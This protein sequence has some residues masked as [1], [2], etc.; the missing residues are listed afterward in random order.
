MSKS[1]A[2]STTFYGL[3]RVNRAK[4]LFMKLTWALIT[5]GSVSF[6]VYIIT[7]TVLNYLKRGV[8][9]STHRINP[10]SN[11]LPSVTFCTVEAI[12]FRTNLFRQAVFVSKAGRTN[13]TGQDFH[14]V[15]LAFGDIPFYHCIK[16]NNYRAEQ[17]LYSVKNTNYDFFLFEV[18]EK[19][20]FTRLE[21]FFSDNYLNTVD[22]S[23]YVAAFGYSKTKYYFEV[24]KSVEKIREEP[25]NDCQLI[26]DLNYRRSNCLLQCQSNKFEANYNCT[27]RN[28][29]AKSSA[30]EY[31]DQIKNSTLFEFSAVCESRCLKECISIKFEAQLEAEA[32][33]A[34]MFLDIFYTDLSY[35]EISQTPIMNGYS[36]INE[37]GGALGLFVGISFLSI[38]EL[39]EYSSEILLILFK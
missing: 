13:L 7:N 35:I 12:E 25:Y 30:L 4:G 1:F 36:L 39:L 33:H 23:Q 15:N 28:Y 26:A 6:C 11:I 34:S 37:M 16:F 17:S 27:L 9:T 22:W 3:N 21:V 24:T 8:S 18:S 29:Y 38:L 31:C 14:E 2:E 10:L 32:G 5:L 19:A 20:S